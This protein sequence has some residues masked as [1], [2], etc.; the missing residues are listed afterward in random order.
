MAIVAHKHTWAA[1]GDG[2]QCLNCS[3]HVTNAQ[4]VTNASVYG[5]QHGR[6]GHDDAIYRVSYTVYGK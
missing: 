1:Q 4:I 6:G 5:G 3:A 2:Y